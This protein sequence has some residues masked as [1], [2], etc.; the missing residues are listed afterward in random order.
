MMTEADVATRVQAHF[1]GRVLE[2][3][4]FRG[5]H[6]ITLAP[7]DLREALLFLR[8]ELGFEWLMDIGGVDYLGY[9]ERDWRFEVVYA[10]L[11]M[12]HNVRFR[13]KVA[14]SEANS[15]VPSVW[16]L[17][18]IA[19]WEEREVWDMYGIV[20][21]NHPNLRRILC[22]DEFVGHALRK[23]Y[24]IT[25]RQKLSAPSE[26]ILCDRSEIA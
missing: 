12:Q 14:V 23:D 2:A 20:F 9:D 15:S 10:M 17:W 3:G 5:Q 19:N 1:G 16:D 6:T 26:N 7:T 13:I 25:R 8:D 18:A 24:P 11:S 21:E 4:A 22:H